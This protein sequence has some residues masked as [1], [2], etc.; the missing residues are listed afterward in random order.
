MPLAL[1][2]TSATISSSTFPHP[3]VQEHIQ[4]Y[5][6]RSS[7]SLPYG[8]FYPGSDGK[9][10]AS[11]VVG[12]LVIV[13]WV[14]GNMLPFFGILKYFGALRVSPQMENIGLD[15]CVCQG[16]WHVARWCVTARGTWRVGACWGR[17]QTLQV[18]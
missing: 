17:L 15:R 2:I 13:G 12:I 9:L 16:T 11:Q 18:W 14:A 4:Q 1:C 8:A 5:Y 6:K 3:A 7:G 10:L